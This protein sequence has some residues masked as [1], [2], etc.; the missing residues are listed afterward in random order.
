M[1]LNFDALL[2]KYKKVFGHIITDFSKSRLTDPM[3]LQHI[4]L[5]DMRLFVIKECPNLLQIKLP[6]GLNFKNCNTKIEITSDCRPKFSK[7]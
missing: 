3:F 5:I 1:C 7:H 6:L 2:Q 4:L